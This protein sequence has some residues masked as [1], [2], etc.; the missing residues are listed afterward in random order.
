MSPGEFTILY[1]S[2]HASIPLWCRMYGMT[3]LQVGR[4]RTFAVTIRTYESQYSWKAWLSTFLC[5]SWD[6]VDANNPLLLE[7]QMAGIFWL[8]EE[9]RFDYLRALPPIERA[10]ILSN[11][12]LEG[13]NEVEENVWVKEQKRIMADRTATA[14][15]FATMTD[16]EIYSE[17]G[18]DKPEAKIEVFIYSGDKQKSKA[19]DVVSRMQAR[20]QRMEEMSEHSS[21]WRYCALCRILFVFSMTNNVW[22]HFRCLC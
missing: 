19:L 15:V 16:E 2:S 17:L 21:C 13:T 9:E 12:P 11:L 7:D 18:Q 6:H 14:T 10:E 5:C 4:R 20:E 8:D 22:R 1:T 3:R